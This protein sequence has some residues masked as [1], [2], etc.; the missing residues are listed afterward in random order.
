MRIQ[1][2]SQPGTQD[3]NQNGIVDSDIFPSS[4][5][6]RVWLIIF[7]LLQ[8]NVIILRFYK[9]RGPPIIFKR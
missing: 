8:S 2:I 7:K 9:I 6:L 1:T 3:N 5:F 4:D